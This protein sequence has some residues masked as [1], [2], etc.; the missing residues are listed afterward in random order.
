MES[1]DFP[2]VSAHPVPTTPRHTNPTLCPGC[3]GKM[4]REP[5]AR[6]GSFVS[7]CA[8]ERYVCDDAACPAKQQTPTRRRP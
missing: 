2:A 1:A 3:G 5:K 7:N 8:G 6:L 4:R